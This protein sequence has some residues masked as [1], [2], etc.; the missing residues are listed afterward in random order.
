[1]GNLALYSEMENKLKKKKK[2]KRENRKVREMGGLI[3]NMGK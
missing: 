3:C 1:M 2:K